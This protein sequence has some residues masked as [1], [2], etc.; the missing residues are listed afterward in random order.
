MSFVL[1][2]C[3]Q[4]VS[5]RNLRS[6]KCESDLVPSDLKIIFTKER[7]LAVPSQQT[8]KRS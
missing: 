2:Q 4:R 7:P 5:Q 6:V 1:L 8:D 3:K